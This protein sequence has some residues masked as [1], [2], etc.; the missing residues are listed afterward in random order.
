MDEHQQRGL[1]V[2]LLDEGSDRRAAG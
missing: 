2:M 1:A